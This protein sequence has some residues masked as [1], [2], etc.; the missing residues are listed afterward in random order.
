MLNTWQKRYIKLCPTEFL[1]ELATLYFDSDVELLELSVL[2]IEDRNLAD[3]IETNKV[4][5]NRGVEP[6]D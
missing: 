1:Y 6:L 3:K 5:T 4:L 2:E